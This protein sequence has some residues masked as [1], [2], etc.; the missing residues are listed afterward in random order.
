MYLDFFLFGDPAR[1]F[2]NHV[3]IIGQNITNNNRIFDQ[4]AADFFYLLSATALQ[5]REAAP[6]S[7][8][9]AA[10]ESAAQLTIS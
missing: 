3:F 7:A 9:S 6:F 5:D 8:R 1:E 4:L 10:P 2:I